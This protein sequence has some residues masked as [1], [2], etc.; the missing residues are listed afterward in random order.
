[1]D[2]KSYPE[3]QKDSLLSNGAKFIDRSSIP[4]DTA[5]P[6]SQMATPP[7]QLF[8]FAKGG[9]ILLRMEMDGILLNPL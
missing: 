8:S 4:C 7:K 1:M 5:Y 9:D 2:S 3:F 6:G